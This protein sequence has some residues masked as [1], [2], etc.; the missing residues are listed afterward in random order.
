[1]RRALAGLMLLAAMAATAHAWELQ[2]WNEFS[3]FTPDGQ[4]IKQDWTSQPPEPL[5]TIT[6][7]NRIP[8]LRNGY[9]SLVLLVKDIKGGPYRLSVSQTEGPP[10]QLDLYRA[11]YHLSPKAP[12]TQPGEKPKLWLPAVP[13]ALVPIGSSVELTLPTADN[14]VPDQKAQMFWL[15]VFVPKDAP[16]DQQVTLKF[17]LNTAGFNTEAY[18][19]MDTQRLAYPD[20]DPITA[21]HNSYGIGFLSGQYP[22]LRAKVGEKFNTSDEAFQLMHEYYKIHYENRGTFHNLGYGHSGAV[23]EQ[24]VPVLGGYGETR[25]PVDWTLF[26]KHFGPLLDGS[27]FKDTRR[28][29]KP[30]DYLY[31]TINPEWPARYVLLGSQGYETEFVNAV[32]QMIQ[33]FEKKGWTKTKFEMFFNHKKRYKGFDWDGDETRWPKDDVYFKLYKRLLAQA[34]PRGTAVQM[35]IRHDASWRMHEQFQS[36]NGIVDLWVCSGGILSWFPWAPAM[37]HERGNLV[38]FYGGTPEAWEPIINIIE[39][40]LQAWKWEVDG[41]CRWLTNSP[42]E[43]PW[44]NFNGGGEALVYSGERFGM[45]KPIPCIRL[46]LERNIIQDVAILKM[47]DAKIKD[48]VAKGQMSPPDKSG[49]EEWWN[50]T[51]QALHTPAAYWNNAFFEGASRPSVVQREKL[52]PNWWLGVRNAGIEGAAR[53]Y[54]TDEE[55][56][57]Q[58][59][60]PGGAEAPATQPQEGSHA[61]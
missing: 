45:E 38:W 2:V 48:A 37:L 20:E 6:R 28:G 7:P 42:G 50:A 9:V 61:K 43:D 17:T 5:N 40:P 33:H 11:W 21:D 3:R 44:F 51:P 34:T 10:V 8:A 31:L 49:A 25:G 1:M 12:A 47:A 56:E 53:T 27:A 15:D 57:R 32:R 35:I 59:H 54:E 13:D 46:K 24:Y 16:P 39:Y 41:Y 29:P 52:D 4:L 26:E 14:R 60:S 36:L 58:A 18:A 30:I 55:I 19:V 23:T 22:Q